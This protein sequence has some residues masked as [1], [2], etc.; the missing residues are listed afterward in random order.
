M[1]SGDARS[2][3]RGDAAEPQERATERARHRAYCRGL[4]SST[5][6]NELQG[7]LVRLYVLPVPQR[8][9]FL[10][11]IYVALALALLD[12]IS[13]DEAMADDGDTDAAAEEE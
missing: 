4:Y 7:L 2:A 13:A 10:L 12:A 5:A 1:G 9:P 6:G 8:K 11:P 3:N